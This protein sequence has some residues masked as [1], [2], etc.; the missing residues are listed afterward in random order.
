[1][2]DEPLATVTRE[3]E[4]FASV[5]A[6]VKLDEELGFL[7]GAGELDIL[8]QLAIA[9]GTHSPR[10]EGWEWLGRCVFEVIEA[11]RAGQLADMREL[12]A[13]VLAA[14][15]EMKADGL[16]DAPVDPLIVG[17]DEVLPYD[18]PHVQAMAADDPALAE[19][20]AAEQ[21]NPWPLDS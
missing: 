4:E 7:C 16:P 19:F 21:A 18:H 3:H 5:L 9:M 17:E 13:D 12:V 10:G 20:I 8:H 14:R 11:Q 6:N 1:M 15:A 2:P